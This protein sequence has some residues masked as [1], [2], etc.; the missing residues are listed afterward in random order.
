MNYISSKRFLCLSLLMIF[1]TALNS[2]DAHGTGPV[3]LDHKGELWAKSTLRK[4]SLEEKIGQLI[5]VWAKVE[6][7]NID[8]PA[9]VQL[10]DE[11]QKY[12]VGGFGVTVH[13]DGARLI[14]S[15]PFEA[16]A[17]TNELQKESKYPL[18]FAA[19]FERGLAVR[20]NGAT[21]FPSAM[22]FGATG[23]KDLVR[24][25]GE[26][27]AEESR[28][29]GIHWNWFPVADVNSN[30]ANPIINTRSF[31]ENP[32]VV[33]DMVAAYI[34]GARSE[35][36][37][38]TVKHFPGHGDTDTDS[39]LSLARVT[40]NMDRLNSVELIPFRKAIAAGVDTVMM[41][42]ITVPAIEPDPNLPASVSKRVVTGL[43][44]DK[45]GF[46]GLVVT[47]ALDMGALMHAFTGTDAEISGKEAV[48]ALLAGNDMVIIPADLDGAYSGLIQAAKSGVLSE[49]RID[50]SVLKILRLKA[51]VGLNVDRYVDMSDV[52]RV[53]ARPASVALAQTISDRAITLATDT[54]NLLPL[55]VSA[56][57]GQ[58][59]ASSAVAVIFTNDARA[60]EGVGAFIA[61][62]RRRVPNA[63]VFLVDNSS[64]ATVSQD[65]LAAVASASTV[66]AVAEAFPSARRMMRVAGQQKGSAGLDQSATELLSSIVKTA[67]AKTVVAAFGNPY[68]GSD[69]P[70]ISTY[71][72]T[73][74]D[75]A[76][77]A[78]SLVSALF[79]ENAIHGRLPVTIPNIARI[80]A[81]LDRAA[82]AP[83]VH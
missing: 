66:I 38:T 62:L 29:V 59:T 65:V 24:Q 4:M 33:G 48:Q 74:S 15:E 34:D 57:A 51:S 2:V 49:K 45:L 7:L 16:A 61:Q 39:H 52:S 46:R 73:F 70:G 76:D 30:P 19:D 69:V 79:G 1:L 67:G 53:V 58:A 25:F 10:H 77:S 44:K 11:M 28:A 36:L 23:D 6:Y 71:V 60:S 80:G 35:G 12:H 40:G 83:V 37:L 3:H 75:T 47:D 54:N 42:H 20:L 8:S 82:T 21:S 5:M 78:L 13:V 9:F 18:I 55:H 41:G 43:L 72:C 68:I 31:S 32:A 56:D 81:G 26:I 64:S 17:L 27:S 14:K 50:E 22:A 63:S